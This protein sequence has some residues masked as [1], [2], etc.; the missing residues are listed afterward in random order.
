MADFQEIPQLTK[1][2]VDMSKEYLR[3]ETIEPA[4]KL[5]KAAGMGV[6]GAALFSLGA[7]LALLGV[8]ALMKMVLPDG[9]WYVV[10]A[11]VITAVVAVAGA[12]LVAWRMSGDEQGVE[13][14]D[15]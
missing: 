8:Y 3:Q 7:F 15:F 2:L 10:L 14:D 13:V 4:K 11:R 1:D 6:G 12:G 9:E 5:G